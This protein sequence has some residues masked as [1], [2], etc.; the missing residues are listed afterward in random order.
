MKFLV[1]AN[2]TMDGPDGAG[3]AEAP[4]EPDPQQVA[5][6]RFWFTHEMRGTTRWEPD[7]AALRDGPTRIVVGIGEE[8]AGQFCD[9]TA[10]ALAAALGVEPTMFPGGHI[11]FA[12]DPEGFV[13]R[14]REVLA[15]A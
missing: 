13:V 12:E 7:V 14:L 4:G 1:N 8:S 2:I 15:G 9:R 6:E 5:D 11:A 3:P 10:T